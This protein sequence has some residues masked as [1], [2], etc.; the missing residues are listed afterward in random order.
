M[1]HSLTATASEAESLLSQGIA[2]CQQRDFVQGLSLIRQAIALNPKNWR[3][4]YLLGAMYESAGQ[5][6]HAIA[7]TRKA[8]GIKPDEPESWFALAELYR[9]ADQLSE[10]HAAYERMLDISPTHTLAQDALAA[11]NRKQV[12]AWHFSM[13]NDRVRNEAY[14]RSIAAQVKGKIVLEIGAGSGLLSMMAAR[15]GATHVY[16]CEMMPVIAAKA[17]EIIAQNG[18]S[19]RITIIT[20]SSFDL[21]L[22]PNELPQ[23][24]DVLITETFD[25]HLIGENMLAIV[26]DAR[27]R[28]LK[29][30]AVI[31]PQRAALMALP[32]ESAALYEQI[33][34]EHVSGFDLSAFNRFRPQ[35]SIVVTAQNYAFRALGPATA[36]VQYDLAHDALIPQDFTLDL[37]LNDSGLCHGILT[38]IRLELGNGAVYEHSP[39]QAELPKLHWLHGWH[40]WKTPKQVSTDFPVPIHARYTSKQFIF[41]LGATD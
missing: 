22:A 10:A 2:L 24:A 30:D 5:L 32:I 21:K 1:T 12:K 20:K 17:R 8:T 19:E 34:V 35:P 16:A 28:L 14:E 31:I 6:P 4:H 26:A 41:S 13:M 33:A 25:P 36:V 7:S 27:A 37:P 9:K 11:L 18:L 39:L 3:Y 29:P 40:A 23:H 38:W 15:A